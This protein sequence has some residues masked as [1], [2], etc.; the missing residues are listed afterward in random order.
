MDKGRGGRGSANVCRYKNS[1]V[2]ILLTS[3]NV[4]KGGGDAYPQNVNS[5][6]FFFKPF[7]NI[8]TL[9][10]TYMEISTANDCATKM[11]KKKYIPNII[12]LD[13]I[14]HI[15]A[16]Y[17]LYLE[18]E[19]PSLFYLMLGCIQTWYLELK[20]SLPFFCSQLWNVYIWSEQILFR[21]FLLQFLLCTLVLL[22][23]NRESRTKKTITKRFTE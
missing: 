10:P 3:A 19:L 1:L 23:Y 15:L 13:W 4:D 11:K 20:Y 18:L 2:W 21:T 9:I 22:Q 7:P 16:V 12:N 14:F 8:I 6:P 5:L 17:V